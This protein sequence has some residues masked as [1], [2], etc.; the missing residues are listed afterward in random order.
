MLGANGGGE[1][2]NIKGKKKKGEYQFMRTRGADWLKY[3]NNIETFSSTSSER[4]KCPD[5]EIEQ[6]DE[7]HA[8]IK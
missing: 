1:L 5:D 6:S 2:L 3:I 8:N 4:N 7:S